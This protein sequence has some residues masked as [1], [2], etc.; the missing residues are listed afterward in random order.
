MFSH[1]AELSSVLLKCGRSLEFVWS[2]LLPQVRG[3]SAEFEPV[4]S[5]CWAIPAGNC[6]PNTVESTAER[7]KKASLMS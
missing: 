6:Y 3:Y 5:D 1:E 2:E 4:G 7:Q